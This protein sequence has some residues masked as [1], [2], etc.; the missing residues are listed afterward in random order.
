MNIFTIFPGSKSNWKFH[1]LKACPTCLVL[2]AR[3]THQV[4]ATFRAP[5]YHLWHSHF[6]GPVSACPPVFRCNPGTLIL[7]SSFLLVH[8][9]WQR[10][11][12]GSCQ[13]NIPYTWYNPS[14]GSRSF[15]LPFWSPVNHHHLYISEAHYIAIIPHV[16][17]AT[18]NSD[19]FRQIFKTSLST[20]VPQNVE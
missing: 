17:V 19:E 1:I 12:L 10:D 2:T 5:L 13:R 16:F 18:I 6:Q 15:P 11:L 8:L 20:A 7:S 4:Y 14:S 9:R 3:A